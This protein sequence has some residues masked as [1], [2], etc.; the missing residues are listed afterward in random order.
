MRLVFEHKYQT[1]CFSEAALKRSDQ[2]Q[3]SQNG[4]LEHFTQIQGSMSEDEAL[5][6]AIHESMLNEQITAANQQT[7][8]AASGSKNCS[9]S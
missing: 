1:L 8:T 5:A 9:I 7:S 4:N 2:Q 6:K 3:T